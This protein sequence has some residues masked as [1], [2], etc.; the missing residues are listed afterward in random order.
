MHSRLCYRRFC[1]TPIRSLLKRTLLRIYF[2]APFFTCA[3][4]LHC[5]AIRYPRNHYLGD[6]GD[7]Y[8]Y[9][10]DDGRR[11]PTTAYLGVHCWNFIAHG[12]CNGHWK[13]TNLWIIFGTF[14]FVPQ[15][16]TQLTTGGGCATGQTL[17]AVPR[18]RP[19]L[20]TSEALIVFSWVSELALECGCTF[21][22]R[23]LFCL[24]FR[25]GY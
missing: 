3:T 25:P 23:F 5:T 4:F 20:L 22:F 7:T 13:D 11:L 17:F 2:C 19:A 21:G 8:Y 12:R 15:L 6:L 24:V 14:G 10:D 1:D 9:E 16:H 18:P